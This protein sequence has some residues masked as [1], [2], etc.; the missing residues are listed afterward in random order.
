MAKGDFEN[1]LFQQTLVRDTAFL[2]VAHFS[3]RHCPLLLQVIPIRKP[4][5]GANV[6]ATLFFNTC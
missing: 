3:L 6:S 2:R 4:K 5:A 1:C